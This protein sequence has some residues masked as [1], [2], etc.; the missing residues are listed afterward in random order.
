MILGIDPDTKNVGFGIVDNGKVIHVGA[1]RQKLTGY[2][3]VAG[4]SSALYDEL[5][6][7]KAWPITK[8][9]VEGQQ[10]YQSGP[11]KTKNPDDILLLAHITGVIV[12]VCKFIWPQ[13]NISIFKPHKWKGNIPKRTHQARLLTLL[14]WGYE[15]VGE[16]WARPLNPAFT[17][18][19]AGLWK[20]VIDGVGLAMFREED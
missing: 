13:A 14:G 7:L 5:S 19:P 18:E 15:F 10:I 12:S 2:D 16:E 9:H 4:M 6:K 17:L 8:I 11:H 1:A 20:H 3:S